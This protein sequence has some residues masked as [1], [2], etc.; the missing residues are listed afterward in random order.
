MMRQDSTDPNLNRISQESFDDVREDHTFDILINH[1][2]SI[3]DIFP[4]P[5]FFDRPHFVLLESSLGGRYSIAASDPLYVLE[6]REGVSFLEEFRER[7][8][9]TPRVVAP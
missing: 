9:G 2:I 3:K 7:L 4:D 6:A 5:S 8:R 1:M